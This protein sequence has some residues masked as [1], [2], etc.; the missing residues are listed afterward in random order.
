MSQY[1]ATICGHCKGP[2]S[3]GRHHDCSEHCKGCAEMRDE[4]EAR[5]IDGLTAPKPP[6][7]APSR[8]EQL[9]AI[10][11]ELSKVGEEKAFA[12]IADDRCVFCDVRG[13]Y[14]DAFRFSVEHSPDC[15]IRR[16]RELQ[17]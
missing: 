16:S 7:S 11:S 10:V 5:V 6:E 4:L 1:E 12:F 17:P 14:D 3:F 9:E 13:E 2:M 15:L 8:L